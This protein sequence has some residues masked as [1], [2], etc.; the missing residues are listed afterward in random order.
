MISRRLFNFVKNKIPKISSTELIALRSGNT[1]LD[2]SILLG[3][4]KFPEK[5]TLENKFPQSKLNEL[6]ST[7]DGTRVYP[8]NNSNYWINYLA[9]NKYFSF[10]IDESY[11]GI[12]LSVNET[13]NMLTKIAS[14]DPALGVVTM[15]PNSLGPGEL[16]THYGTQEQKN[17]YL[18]GLADGTYI[19][20]FGLTG[21]NNGSDATGSIDEGNV[22]KVNG[23]TMIKVK[24][25]KRYI[26]L[27]PVANLMGIAF[28]LKDPD[29]ILT[30]KKSGI[31][32]AL[33]ERGHKGLI[34]ETY[35]NPLNAGFP[36]GTIK[37]EFLINPEQIIGGHENIGNG[38][39]MLMDCLS[40]GRGISLPATANASSKAATFGIIN[41][42]K[43]RSQ[44]NMSLS[45]ME[46]IK[47]KINAMVFN[48]WIIQSSIDLTNDI[49]DAGNSP[50]VLSAIMKQ[51]TTERG[52]EV[53]NHGMDIQGGGA[54]CLGYSN[55]LEKFYRAAPIGITV[56]GSNTLTRSLII[57]GQGLNKSHPHIFPI[58]ENVLQN[59]EKTF[60]KN[61]KSIL[62]H[63]LN[64]Y[65][66]TFNFTNLFPGVPKILAKQL[67]DF[68]CLTNFVAL[69]GGSLKREQ[70]L[71][72]AM[73]DIF[74]NLYLAL[75]VE[76][77]HNNY[78]ASL[79]LTN[80]I[81][82]KLVNENQ[83]KI[84]EVINN[85]GPER[86]LLKHLINP[87]YNTSYEEE[88]AIFNEIMSNN[89]IMEELKKNIYVENNILADLE[90]AGSGKLDINSDE[91]KSLKDKIIN[92]DEFKN[93]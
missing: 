19:P 40:A 52:R 61:F 39:Q 70:M 36:N 15:V 33:L 5:K 6:L 60:M 71:S 86:I 57:F 55:F 45:N 2:R 26:T 50:A 47:E 58:L 28:N 56:E 27:A 82:N 67:I 3:K 81:I 35:H 91:Y 76:Y 18:P 41:Y 72:G 38:W 11:G 10:L 9:K 12:K 69:K 30:S 77:Y 20:C 83:N 75:S 25:N 21:P 37:G 73:A 14:L 51:Q 59:D 64:L 8:N 84:N 46:A 42:A 16:L 93:C 53:L 92:V 44:F 24:I 80:Y 34:Q 32:L 31:T 66:S 49:L 54:I 63:S 85:L 43:V 7:Y 68:A 79:K 62:N 78:N 65:F 23:R 13:S 22:I 29:Q 48:T 4:I 89:K 88:N 1:S 17:K 87:V 90:L 74:S